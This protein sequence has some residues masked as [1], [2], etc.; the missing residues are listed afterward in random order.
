VSA[1]HAT[2]SDAPAVP[3]DDTSELRRHGVSLQAIQ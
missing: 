3:A 1:R 2:H